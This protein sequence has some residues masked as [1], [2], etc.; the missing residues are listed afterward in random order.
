MALFNN[1]LKPELAIGI[2]VG[3]AAVALAPVVLPAVATAAR[4]LARTAVKTGIILFEQGQEIM[5]E[6]SEFLD[7][8]IAEARAELEQ[9][10][11]QDEAAAG[12]R[13][14]RART[15]KREAPESVA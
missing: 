7:D 10:T 5:A 11:F 15:A 6:G 9:E 4:P 12:T 13:D 2:A 1:F 3:A 14:T 8:L